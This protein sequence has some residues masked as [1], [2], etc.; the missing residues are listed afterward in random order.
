MDPESGSPSRIGYRRST[1]AS[2]GRRGAADRRG[3]RAAWRSSATSRHGRHARPRARACSLPRSPLRPRSGYTASTAPPVDEPHRR[4]GVLADVCARG[5][6]PPIGPTPA[7]RAHLRIG[8]VLTPPA[9]C[10]SRSS[11]FRPLGASWDWNAGMS[12]SGSTTSWVHFTSPLRRRA[13]GPVTSRA[14]PGVERAVTAAL[15]RGA[16]PGDRVP[17]P[18]FGLRCCSRQMAERPLV[19]RLGRPPG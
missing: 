18:A 19:A 9:G 3:R 15:G 4:R 8:L 13:R 10:G 17:A 7:A 12:G 6:P 1:P 16:P 2:T 14:L 5:R 11:D